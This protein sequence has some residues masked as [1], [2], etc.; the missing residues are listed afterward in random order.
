MSSIRKQAAARSRMS[1]L[2]PN[3][4]EVE[5]NVPMNFR[6]LLVAGVV[7]VLLTGTS[8]AFIFKHKKHCCGH[9]APAGYIDCQGNYVYN[10]IEYVQEQR[11]VMRTTYKME[12]RQEA[13]TAYRCETVMVPKTMEV[14]CNRLVTETVMV[15]KTVCER[16]PTWET[17]TVMKQVCT[18]QQVTEMVTRKVDKGHWECREVPVEEH[19]KMGSFGHLL[20][21]E[22]EDC[23]CKCA[24]PQYVCK[25]CWVPC[26]VCEQVPVTVCKKVTNCV[27]TQVQVC[28]YHTVQKQVTV[29]CCV[30]KCVQ[31]RKTV[32]C[33]VCEKRQVPVQCTRT[34]CCCVPV[35]EAVTVCC[36]VP[37]C[38][39]HKVPACSAPCCCAPCCH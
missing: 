38:V 34:V 15:N 30:T 12:Q 14:C 6:H 2:P 36:C 26:I 39:Q 20:H 32:T 3:T 27:P 5:R 29:P 11:Q 22:K 19:K 8:Q 37:R 21:R 31:E 25:Q 1:D 9:G 23:C 35:Q 17:K 33:N 7:T 16:V 24:C 4:F 28:C 10:T 13:Y 18:T